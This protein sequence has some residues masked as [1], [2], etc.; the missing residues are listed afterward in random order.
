MAD[1]YKITCD[2]FEVPYK[3]EHKIL[4]APRL[5]FA[6]VANLDLLNL[7]A[8]LPTRDTGSLTREECEILD[9]LDQK[10]ILNG[11]QESPISSNPPKQFIPTQLTL[12]PT[13]QCNMRCSY[14]YASSGEEKSNIMNLAI[15]KSAV[16]ILIKNLKKRKMK[17]LSLGF[18]GGGEPLSVWNLIT[19][20][21]N[22]CKKRCQVEDL[23][24]SVSSATNGIL[25]E[26]Q[27]KWIVRNFSSLN[28]SFDGLPRVQDYHRLLLN[29][30]GSFKLVDRTMRFLDECNFHYAIRSTIS[31]YNLDLMRESLDFIGQN[32]KTKTVHF[33][34]LFY[35]GRC[36]TSGVMNPDLDKFFQYYCDCEELSA[37]Y[38]ISL[39]YSG[40]RIENLTNTFCG[41]AK[42][43]FAVTPDGDITACYEVTSKD[44]PRSQTFFIGY[45]DKNGKLI[46]NEAK[47]HYLHS[48]TVDH[49]E[50]C[51][52]CFAKWH[53]A[54]ECVAK[55]GHQNYRGA[56]GH[57]RCELNRDL[58]AYRLTNLI[59]A[60]FNNGVSVK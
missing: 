25:N 19:R 8:G 56:R 10:G 16:E 55:I 28:I 13:N 36:R 60:N 31:S 26:K 14:C 24:F 30:D 20:I 29:G 35:C 51:Q 17:L 43:N 52:N 45:I 27:L 18:H 9:F 42:D 57:D 54:G 38:G 1:S 21:V 12:F 2:L 23:Q 3:E 11:S 47:R 15:A 4:Y 32:Y 39:T 22:Y 48:L 49:L 6:C 44:D 46:I 5:G 7:L 58:T 40:S 59:E 34:P 37:R 50:Y 41:V 53:C 33:E